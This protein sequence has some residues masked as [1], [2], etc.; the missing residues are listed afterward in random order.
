MCGECNKASKELLIIEELDGVHDTSLD[1]EMPSFTLVA[2][3][4]FRGK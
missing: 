4:N 2:K 1:F 3:G